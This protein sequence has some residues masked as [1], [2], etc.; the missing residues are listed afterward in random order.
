MESCRVLHHVLLLIILMFITISESAPHNVRVTISEAADLPC[1]WNCSALAKWSLINNWD[2]VMAECDQTSCRS[3]KEGFKVSHE[4]F[5]K[6]DLT[7]TITAA[8]YISESAPSNVRVKVNESAH[9]SCKYECSDLAKWSLITNR[10]DV[11]ARCDR[12]SCR[13]VKEGFKMPHDLYLKGDLTLTAADYSKRNVYTCWCGYRGINDVRLGIKTSSSSVHINPG[14]DLLMDLHVPE[15]VKVIFE[16]EEIY[17]VDQS[18]LHCI[19]EYR[20][21]TSL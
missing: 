21:R 12:T 19:E 18:S 6:G 2:N 1:A 17:R 16:S 9:L 14:E 13:S 7:L 10:R 8:D 11:V 3:V 20:S 5:L 4:L 15:L